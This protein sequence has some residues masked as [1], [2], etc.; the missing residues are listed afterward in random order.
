MTSYTTTQLTKFLKAN[1]K[2]AELRIKGADSD[3]DGNLSGKESKD[4]GDIKDS[5]DI[6][7][8]SGGSGRTEEFLKFYVQFA[9]QVLKQGVITPDLEDNINNFLGIQGGTSKLDIS[10][11]IG[12]NFSLLGGPDS[13]RT[14]VEVN[15]K[16]LKSAVLKKGIN[17][18]I[19]EIEGRQFSGTNYRANVEAVFAVKNPKQNGKIMAYIVWGLGAGDGDYN[20]G[21]M[22]VLTPKGKAL[23]EEEQAG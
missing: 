14:I 19:K 18:A 17:G 4:L 9:Q 23:Y 16:R 12:K 7:M 6:Y 21:V 2:Y 15:P 1:P 8:K 13:D 10:E 5:F 3:G 20:D 11:F 22:K